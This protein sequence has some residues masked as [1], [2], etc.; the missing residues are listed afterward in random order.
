V[1]RRGRSR[2]RP[3]HDEQPIGCFAITGI[4]AHGLAK[5]DRRRLV[6]IATSGELSQQGVRWR[7]IGS[8]PDD[9]AEICLCVE[10]AA[11]AHVGASAQQK[12]LYA[13]G[14]AFEGI[15]TQCDHAGVMTTLEELGG[16]SDDT[17][18]HAA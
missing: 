15:A 12:Q 13:L 10:M 14:F 8:E 3:G 6:L 4:E 7:T 5:K 9:V 11:Q 17:P 1:C 16:G 2:R 18:V